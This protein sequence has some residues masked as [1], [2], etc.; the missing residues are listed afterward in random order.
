MG[1]EDV[2]DHGVRVMFTSCRDFKHNN[3]PKFMYLCSVLHV[4]YYIRSLCSVGFTVC[5]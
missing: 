5:D 3:R 1:R 2:V 4:L